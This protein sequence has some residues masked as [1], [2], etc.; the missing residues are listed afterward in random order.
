MDDSRVAASSVGSGGR[1]FLRLRANLHGVVFLMAGLVVLYAVHR[2]VELIPVVPY[3]ATYHAAEFVVDRIDE[4]DF[5]GAAA[6][7][8]SAEG[9][10]EPGGASA[11]EPLARTLDGRLVLANDRAI[12]AIAG[13]RMRVW[14]SAEDDAPVVA[15][16]QMPCI[17]DS[18]MIGVWIV[19]ALGAFGS[20]LSLTIRAGRY[21]QRDYLAEGRL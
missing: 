8:A 2:I 1:Y 13:Q 7:P 10:V 14:F 9:H 3:Q 12:A 15:V 4:S 20:G 6:R 5:R 16:A 19:F 18:R 17:P 21:L 11:T